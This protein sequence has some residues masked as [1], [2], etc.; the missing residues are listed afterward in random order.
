MRK[1]ENR[2]HGEALHPEEIRDAEE[3][4][5]RRVQIEAFPEEYQALKAKRAILPKSRL[6]KLSPRIDESGIIRMDGRLTN[7]DYLPY[8]TKRPIILPRGHHVTKLI[9]KHYHDQANHAGGMS[10]ILAPLTPRFLITAAREEI[11]SWGNECNE[12]KKGKT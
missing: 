10:F 8:D 3:A 1:K 11:R 5:I 4:I 9:L 7:A 12:C 2:V 6:I